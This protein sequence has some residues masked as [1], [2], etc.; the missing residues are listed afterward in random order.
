MPE[1]VQG[2]YNVA[3]SVLAGMRK[4][5]KRKTVKR[6]RKKQSLMVR[7]TDPSPVFMRICTL[8]LQLS[9]M[10]FLSV[11]FLLEE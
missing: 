8:V 10:A 2:R 4:K 5:S 3:F 1:Y 9:L 6:N 11:V 7:K